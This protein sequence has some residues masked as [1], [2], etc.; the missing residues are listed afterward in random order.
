MYFDPLDKYCLL[1]YY[2]FI[3]TFYYTYIWLI[4][5]PGAFRL[6]SVRLLTSPYM[7]AARLTIVKYFV[8]WHDFTPHISLRFLPTE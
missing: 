7:S 5:P 2:E 1:D 3:S 4:C 8:P 6:R